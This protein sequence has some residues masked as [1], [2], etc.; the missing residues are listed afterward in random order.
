MFDI[1]NLPTSFPPQHQG[2]QPG[3]E[4]NMTPK[5][6]FDNPN[7][8]GSNKLKGK[9]ALI[10]GGDSGIGRA[11]AIA[12]AKEGADIVISYLNEEKDANI[13]KDCVEKYGS[14]CF[15]ISGD[16]TLPTHCVEIINFTINNLK[17]LDI[18][19]NNAGV[20]YPE[21]K[22]DSISQ[23]NLET[24]FKTNIFSMFH[25]TQAAIPYLKKGSSIINTAS[26]TAYKGSTDLI[27]YSATKGAIVSFT[28]S[29]SEN[30]VPT[31]VRVNA[32]APGPI[33][34][35][36]IVSSFDEKKVS[37]FGQDVPMKRAGQPFEVA[38]AYVYLASEDSSYVSG[39]VIH[40]N[41]GKI[42][43]S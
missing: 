6:I 13:T 9:V 16:I 39:Q 35:P 25:L 12:F 4:E 40:I 14:K 1:N 33:W 34:T 3:I 7:Y 20:Q 28:R 19:I 36:L 23:K 31:G 22:F 41:G 42:V 15:L 8:I 11:V 43:E 30:L 29:L 5:P 32:I 27:D 26:V 38:P 37:T 18:L 24:T 2:S 17:K 10:T 21:T